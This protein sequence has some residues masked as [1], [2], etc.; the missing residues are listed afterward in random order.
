VNIDAHLD[1]RDLKNGQCH[2]GSPFRLLLNDPDF[3]KRNGN[4]I[5]F[6]SQGLQCSAEHAS[7]LVK[8]GGRIIW[9]DELRKGPTIK[10]SFINL[11]D[12]IGD[13]LFVSFDLDA[14]KYSDAPG[15]SC[16]SPTG[17]TAQEAFDI[18]FEA[19]RHAKV[20]LFDLSEFN[21][22]AEKY[23]TSRLVSFMFYY[24]CCGVAVRKH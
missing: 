22:A 19:G 13:E 23:C 24:F 6:A 9:L 3:G 15:V 7:W 12:L 18:C 14:V 17:L 8:K 20:K 21:P 10:E 11:L 4:F 5:E 2:S 16:A 1:V